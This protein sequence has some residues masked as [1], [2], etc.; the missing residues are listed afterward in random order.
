MIRIDKSWSLFLDRDGVINVERNN[1]YVYEPSQFVF[2]T[3]VL[4]ILSKCNDLFAHILVATNQRGIGRGLMSH[5]NLANVH[6]HMLKEIISHNGRINKIYYAPDL[7]DDALNRKP[8]TGM[9]LQAKKDFPT[10]NFE[11]SIMVGNNISDMEFGKRMEMKTVFVN[12][13]QTQSSDHPMIDYSIK[14]LAALPTILQLT[15]H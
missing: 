8:N 15:T 10:I 6:N 7:E 1:D 2:D 4:D 11:K 12:T 3:G 14:N 13:T 9:A 5:Q